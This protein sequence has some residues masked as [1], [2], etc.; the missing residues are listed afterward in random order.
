MWMTERAEFI[1]NAQLSDRIRTRKSRGRLNK[2][3][4]NCAGLGVTTATGWRS[5]SRP[6]RRY[7]EIIATKAESNSS[8]SVA[9]YTCYIAPG[10]GRTLAKARRLY[11]QAGGIAS[12]R[13]V[14]RIVYSSPPCA[15]GE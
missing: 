6:G 3:I 8:Y 10:F 5:L 13:E 4:E 15:A 7:W 12:C 14:S 2:S 11:M 9:T 1:G